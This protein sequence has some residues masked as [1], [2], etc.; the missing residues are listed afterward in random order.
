MVKITINGQQ[1][2]VKEGLTILKAAEAL[3]IHI[4][5]LCY[6]P[7]FPPEG[8][9]RMCLV[10]VEGRPKLELACSTIVQEGMVIST[11]SPAVVQ[12]RQSVLEFLL[13]EH[14]LDCPLCD[15]AGECKLQDYYELYGLFDGQFKETKEKRDKRVYLGKK[16]I[17][18]RERCILCTRCV[19]FLK[20]VTRTG[21]LGVFQRGIHSEINY[22]PGKPVNNN[23]SGN[24]AELCPVGAITDQDF[25]FQTRSWFLDSKPSICPLCSRVCSVYID[26]HRGFPR[27]E[28]DK[29]IYRL[30][31]RENPQINNY[32]LCD[33]G[34]YTY[35]Y[36]ERNRATQVL[37][38]ENGH[39]VEDDWAPQLDLLA[40][41]LKE[42]YLKKR[43][44][45]IAVI[46]NSALTTEEL[47]LIKKLFAE[48]LPEIKL[49]LLDPEDGEG[50]GFLLTPFRTP[51]LNG[52]KLIGLHPQPFSVA[53]FPEE[54]GL[55][56]ILAYL[57]LGDGHYQAL[58][59]VLEGETYS[60][61]MTAHQT[62]LMDK[63][64][65]VLPTLLP[66]EK[67]GSMV[68]V[69]GQLQRFEKALPA[70]G[71]ARSEGEILGI[72]G[73]K[74]GI[75]F[76]FYRDIKKPADIFSKISQEFSLAEVGS[77]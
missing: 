1:A 75:D 20:E 50:D 47:Y 44:N 48:E 70:P 32:W 76:P 13:A 19:R 23:Y 59:P 55:I 31:A 41:K 64:D 56:I 46:F 39:L 60:V 37:A 61:L 54:L 51:N 65:L 22:F 74:L 49:Y 38:R 24:L 36:L 33:F 53:S 42:L 68:N 35:S 30:R 14:P 45:Q 7:A 17:L 72:I 27:V 73:R 66:Q 34:R 63:V 69:D 21:E 52:V 62:S 71:E 28:L 57:P 29:Y 2:E 10:E 77:D 18:D 4:P 8:S 16:L 11:Q 3:G 25:R 40:K 26:Y 15:K 6:H 67:E 5:H 9:C 12:A 43:T 58:K